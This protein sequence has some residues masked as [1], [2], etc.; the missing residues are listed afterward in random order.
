VVIPFLKGED[1]LTN[2]A[3][4]MVGF[5]Y[6]GAMTVEGGTWTHT[7]ATFDAPMT[8]SISGSNFTLGTGQL[9]EIAW[10]CTGPNATS[11]TWLD[12][13]PSQPAAGAF[14]LGNGT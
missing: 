2:P 8:L 9:D 13:G 7:M 1:V 12:V 11:K 4:F 10:G 3:R 6:G 14:D 5:V